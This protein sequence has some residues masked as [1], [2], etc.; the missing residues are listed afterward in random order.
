M[1]ALRSRRRLVIFALLVAAQALVVLALV[2]REERLLRTGTEVI[3]EVLPVDPRDPLRGDFVIMSYDAQ[4]LR[5][6][7][8]DFTSVGDD[9]YVVLQQRGPYWVPTEYRRERVSPSVLPT[10]AVQIRGVVTSR[11]PDL[12][13]DYPNLDRFYVPEGQGVFPTDPDGRP[14]LPDAVVVVSGDGTARLAELLI[15]GQPWP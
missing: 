14:R 15:D 11:Q 9:V 6:V 13:V 1:N 2:V 8:G 3:L 4:D 7:P 12:R 10:G 5:A